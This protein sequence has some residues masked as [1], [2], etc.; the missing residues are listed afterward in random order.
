MTTPLAY[1]TIENALHQATQFISLAGIN[2]ATPQAD[3]SHTTARW[4]QEEL[5]L[6]SVLLDQLPRPAFLQ[7]LV[8]EFSLRLHSEDG[9]LLAAKDLQGQRIDSVIRWLRES[10]GRE[11]SQ[12][13]T[14]HY[15]LP[16]GRFESSSELHLFESQSLYDW[17]LYRNLAQAGLQRLNEHLAKPSPIL[18]WPHHF[19]SGTHYTFGEN[20]QGEETVG[21]GAGLAIADSMVA[22][23]YFYLYGH[24]Q[25][26]KL[27]FNDAPDLGGGHW[28]TGTWQGAV[29]PVSV[30]KQRDE[31]A[32]QVIEQFYFCSADF[33]V[34]QF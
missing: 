14:L 6:C 27:H 8:K 17:I 10:L 11:T 19:D 1:T 2:A 3:D 5:A 33:L 15:E 28:E 4:Q 13:K 20:D 12:W 34:G 7:L 29:L 21:L 32:L 9:T 22:E 30:L 26:A 18:I 24:K 16:E 31:R 23:P 25:A